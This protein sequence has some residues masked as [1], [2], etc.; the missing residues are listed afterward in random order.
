[1]KSKQSNDPLTA[2]IYTQHGPTPMLAPSSTHTSTAPSPADLSCDGNSL[3]PFLL[4]DLNFKYLL[5]YFSIS[6]SYKKKGFI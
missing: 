2:N 6:W 4:N 3:S 5:D 1:M